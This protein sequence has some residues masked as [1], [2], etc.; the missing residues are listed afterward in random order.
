M[1]VPVVRAAWAEVP[2][3]VPAEKPPKAGWLE[4]A[5]VVLVWPKPL[6][7]P[8]ENPRPPD[9]AAAVDV[10]TVVVAAVVAPKPD[11]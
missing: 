6:P 9:V 5:V 7:K 10:V 8:P 11:T 2:A 4:V 3:T 1:V